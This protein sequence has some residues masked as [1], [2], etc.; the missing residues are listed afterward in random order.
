MKLSVCIAVYNAENLILETLS[1]VKSQTF[2]DFECILVDDHSTDSTPEII[3]D[4]IKEDNRFKFFMNLT[5]KTYPYTDSHNKS[6]ELASGEYLLRLDQD[7]IPKFDMFDKLVKYLDDNPNVDMVSTGFQSF[8]NTFDPN[9]QDIRISKDEEELDELFKSN[10]FVYRYQLK[11][12]T[13]ANQCSCIRRSFL[14]KHP[15][16]FEEFKLGD[17]MFWWRMLGEGAE[18]GYIPEKLLYYRLHNASTSHLSLYLVPSD[19]SAYLYTVAS[20]KLKAMHIWYEKT[21]KV[22]Y[23]CAFDKYEYLVNKLTNNKK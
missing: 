18:P 4:F 2:K 20:L 7:D 8:Y 14:D 22:E 3:I 9:V 15:I 10:N 11:N 17:V 1:A 23:K 12:E 19:S 13:W 16:K 21:N 6:Y 5:D